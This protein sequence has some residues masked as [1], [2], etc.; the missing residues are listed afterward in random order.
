[1]P[2]VGETGDGGR[3]HGPLNTDVDNTTSEYFGIVE[4][5]EQLRRFCVMPTTTLRGLVQV[6]AGLVPTN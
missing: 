2:I 1:M 3:H 4:C 5:V 6:V